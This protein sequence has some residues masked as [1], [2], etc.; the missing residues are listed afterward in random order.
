[1]SKTVYSALKNLP[2]K[3]QYLSPFYISNSVPFSSMYYG[4][5]ELFTSSK[6]PY[7]FKTIAKFHFNYALSLV[8]LVEY[9]MNEF[10]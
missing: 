2:A 7:I 3:F 6:L 1:M 4:L 5:L 8:I 10:G 9:L